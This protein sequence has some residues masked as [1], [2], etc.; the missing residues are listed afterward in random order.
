MSDVLQEVEKGIATVGFCHS[1]QLFLRQVV[2]K[3]MCEND[4]GKQDY[5]LQ[6]F[7]DAILFSDM[8][9]LGK[10]VAHDVRSG[11]LKDVP[12]VFLAM[13]YIAEMC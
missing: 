9:D 4:K 13:M 8:A 3:F 11:E 7:P 5:L 2:V 12:K 6:A 1:A 10:G